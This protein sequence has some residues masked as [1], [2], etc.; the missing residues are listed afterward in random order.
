MP[1]PECCLHVLSGDS[2]D[3]HPDGEFSCGE[4]LRLDAADRANGINQPA[5]CHRLEEKMAGQ[6]SPAYRLPGERSH[7]EAGLLLCTQS[8]LMNGW[9]M[10]ARLLTCP[11]RVHEN[12]AGE[13]SS[14]PRG[15]AKHRLPRKA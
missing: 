2:G 7:G 12:D 5:L 3:P 1:L 4:D 15:I 14:S 6:P 9:V 10:L 8:A 11:A 13:A